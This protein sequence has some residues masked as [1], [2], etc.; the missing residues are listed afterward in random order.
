MSD[1]YTIRVS[2]EVCLL[3]VVLNVY[4]VSW[5]SSRSSEYFQRCMFSQLRIIILSHNGLL[6]VGDG[7]RWSFWGFYK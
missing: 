3:S 6:S 5:T 7:T 2:P 4:L 1:M